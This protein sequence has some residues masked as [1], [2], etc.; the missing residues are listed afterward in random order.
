M[1][2]SRSGRIPSSQTII[3]RR[4]K[5]L[6]VLIA[7][8]V[9]LSISEAA[10]N[11]PV[12]KVCELA[13][14]AEQTDMPTSEIQLFCDCV[15]E[16]ATPRLNSYQLSLFT[17]ASNP[18]AL[19]QEDLEAL[20]A[21]IESA[22][23]RDVIVAAEARCSDALY[24]TPQA[25][26][27]T[28]RDGSELVLFCDYDLA[29]PTLSFRKPGL[30]LAEE[31][32]ILDGMSDFDSFPI[33]EVTWQV[34]REDPVI[35]DWYCNLEGDGVDAESAGRLIRHLRDGSMLKIRIRRA[36]I[37]HTAVFDIAGKIPRLWRACPDR[38]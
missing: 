16:D 12:A 36:D 9:S 27:L 15:S 1:A 35:E 29:V 31:E 14:Q 21:R 8:L 30:V 25:L 6:L 37:E 5:Y 20:A 17:R 34:D 7:S 33:A 10:R 22:G 28:A 4:S 32:E 13:F 23:I 11:D 38:G 19:S 3:G 24:T 2:W 26:T 18:Q